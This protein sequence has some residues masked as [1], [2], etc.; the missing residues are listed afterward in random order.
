[1]LFLCNQPGF[2][3]GAGCVLGKPHGPGGPEQ[4]DLETV[5]GRRQRDSLLQ[6]YSIWKFNFGQIYLSEIGVDLDS[7]DKSAEALSIES[8]ENRIS[9]I[10]DD[11]S[12]LALE[13]VLFASPEPLGDAELGKII[14]RSKKDI[15]AIIGRLNVK[16]A[17]WNR[18]FRI[19][20]YGSRYRFYTLPDFETYIARLAD[21]PRPLKLSR[22]AL[23]VLSIIAYKQPVVKSEIERIRGINSDGVIRTLIERNL[24]ETAGRSDGPGRPVL[25][26]T[27]REFLEFF[28][29]SDLSELPAAEISVDESEISGALTIIRSPEIRESNESSDEAE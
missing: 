10:L 16:Y 3:A 17:Q 5:E 21:I 1:L 2:I 6:D 28:G 15:S 22:A 26:R 25:Y 8:T 7:G 9:I 23:E 29:I 19:E 11:E 4:P 20:N 27:T 14:G 13:A 18:S 12:E 24:I